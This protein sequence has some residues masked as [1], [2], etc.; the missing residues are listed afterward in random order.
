MCVVLSAAYLVTSRLDLQ[1]QTARPGSADSI[2]EANLRAHLEFLASD[3]LNGRA[4]NSRD[5]WIAATYVASQFRLWN[6]EPFGDNDGYVQAAEIVREQMAAPAVLT[7]GASRFTHGKDMLVTV[8]TG[9]V[10]DSRSSVWAGQ[11]GQARARPSAT[12]ADSPSCLT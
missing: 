12:R 4:S 7:A 6:L 5:E 1:A 3:A 8:L 10:V 11:V 2:T 9:E